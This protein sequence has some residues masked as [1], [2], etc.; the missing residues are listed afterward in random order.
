MRRGAKRSGRGQRK[1]ARVADS[2]AHQLPWI[3]LVNPYPPLEPL[4]GDQLGAIHEASMT[5]LEDYGI[6]V[7]SERVRASFRGA[8]PVWMT[9]AGL[10]DLIGSWYWTWWHWR[11]AHSH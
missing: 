1:L 3:N 5:V 10:Y 7:L 2:L 11:Q 9:A 6:E 8:G 4:S